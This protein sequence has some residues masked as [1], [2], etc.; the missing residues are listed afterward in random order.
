M[1]KHLHTIALVL[2]LLTLLFDLAVWGAVPDLKTV[3]PLI[4]E[5]AD[6]EAFLASMYIGAGSALDGAMPSLGAFGG[7][8]MKDGLGEAFPA[9][10]EAPNLAMDLIFSA[11]YN[12]THNWIKLQYWAP[13]V[14]LVLYLVLWLIRPKKVNLVGKRR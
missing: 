5:S 4:E 3:G 8:V 14:L 12:G 10:I 9:I 7:A 1:R 6:N 2:L 11:S 13:P